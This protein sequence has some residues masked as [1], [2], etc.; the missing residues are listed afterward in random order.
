MRR[1][2]STEHRVALVL[3][4]LL[5][6]LLGAACANNS[7]G[8]ALR[9]PTPPGLPQ[10][11][12]SPSTQLV[13]Q[14]VFISGYT[15]NQPPTSSTE[16]F[17][18][19]LNADDGSVRWRYLSQTSTIQPMVVTGQTVYIQQHTNLSNQPSATNLVALN[20]A[21]GA[22]RW[23]FTTKPQFTLTQAG[24][25]VYVS[26]YD[27]PDPSTN[28]NGGA[29]AALNAATGTVK[30]QT[31]V[32][33]RPGTPAV[34]A[35][36]VFVV[37][38]GGK[39]S[40]LYALDIASGQVRWQSSPGTSLSGMLAAG[41]YGF[42]SAPLVLGN[43][44]L[45]EAI[46]SSASGGQNFSIIAYGV[47]DGQVRWQFQPGQLQAQT[48][49]YGTVSDGSA[50]YLAY[51]A[52]PTSRPVIP[53]YYAEALRVGDGS[54]LWQTPIPYL[55]SPPV[56]AGGSIFLMGQGGLT[57]DSPAD[58]LIALNAHSGVV[59][60]HI[61]SRVDNL[62]GG[63]PVV[64]GN[65]VCIPTWIPPAA[66]TPAVTP[67]P[68]VPR[69]IALTAYNMTTG[70]QTWRNTV[71]ATNLPKPP[72]VDGDTL[73]VL[74][75]RNFSPLVAIHAGDGQVLWRFGGS[76]SAVTSVMLDM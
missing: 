43:L 61:P 3:W 28:S 8:H 40:S 15:V 45:A 75:S 36:A 20:A 72:L 66:S 69:V 54:T 65:L 47:T 63:I 35:S 19:A 11:T 53:K 73:L 4:L 24:D 16:Y 67:S 5:L 70:K 17:V 41:Q 42:A 7:T 62:L 46:Y 13:S 49:A 64:D 21:T 59:Q 51:T 55:P 52:V 23:I 74:F 25:T 39:L 32:N 18:A 22:V 71:E 34:S 50:L 2:L 68:Y 6:S 29:I 76:D 26:S 12:A 44:V 56:L 14:L 33:G 60:W 38:F 48:M 57:S 1:S 37:G 30:W 31:A 10:S 9:T 27:S 58:L